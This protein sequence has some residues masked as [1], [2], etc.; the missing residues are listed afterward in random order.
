MVDVPPDAERCQDQHGMEVR[1]ERADQFTGSL[2]DG[3]LC[4]HV[5]PEDR[6]ALRVPRAALP[7]LPV[8]RFPHAQVNR[9]RAETTARLTVLCR[10]PPHRVLAE[11]ASL[12]ER[13]GSHGQR[14]V[15]R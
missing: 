11:P 7:L 14:A 15:R 5:S 2:D 6:R 12:M 4:L 8:Q 10:A 9:L 3:S 1:D 13:S